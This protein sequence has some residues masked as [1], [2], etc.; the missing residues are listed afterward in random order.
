MA[1]TIKS[2]PFNTIDTSIATPT[3]IVSSEMVQYLWLDIAEFTNEEY[4][5]V[6]YNGVTKTIL[7]TDE[8]KY[9]PIDVCFL[10]KEGALQTFT[11]FKA[12]KDV[13]TITSESFQSNDVIG[14]HQDITYNV[15]SKGKISLNT[16]F[17]TEDKNETIRQILL[18]TKLWFIEDGVKIPI[19]NVTS[20]F[21]KKTRIADKLINY[22]IDFEYAFGTINNV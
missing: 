7:I 14:N 9:T 12:R 5:E 11:F 13:E 15:N 1:I 17:I 6:T 3:S 20:N 18:S 2:Y 10:N 21:Q 22:E 19:L 4:I 16:G 8:C